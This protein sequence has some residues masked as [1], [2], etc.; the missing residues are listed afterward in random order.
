[1]RSDVSLNNDTVDEQIC[2]IYKKQD[3]FV[4]TRYGHPNPNPVLV[5]VHLNRVCSLSFFVMMSLQ[6]KYSDKIYV[7]NINSRI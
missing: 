4:L 3:Y 1:M 2:Q 6:H 7:R 5:L